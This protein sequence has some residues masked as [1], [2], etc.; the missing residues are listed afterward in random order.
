MRVNWFALNNG[1][2]DLKEDSWEKDFDL[3]VWRKHS[4]SIELDDKPNESLQV[5]QIWELIGMF[6]NNMIALET[7]ISLPETEAFRRVEA[8]KNGHRLTGGNRLS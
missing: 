1:D 8:V 5:I 4:L 6:P 3:V 2:I 7:F